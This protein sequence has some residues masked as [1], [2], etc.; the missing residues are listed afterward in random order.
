MLVASAR[1]VVNVK[2]LAVQILKISAI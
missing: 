2:A 1:Y